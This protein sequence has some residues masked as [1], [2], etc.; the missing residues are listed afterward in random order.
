MKFK[1][2]GFF[3]IFSCGIL[4]SQNTNLLI[5][6]YQTNSKAA[7]DEFFD[8]WDKETIPIMQE[9]VEKDTSIT[10]SLY[11]L[12]Y[13]FYEC[14]N[15]DPF[16][17]YKLERYTN[18]L[19]DL[20]YFVVRDKIDYNILDLDN[21]DTTF[22]VYKEAWELAKKDTIYNFRPNFLLVNSEKVIR[23]LFLT[24]EFYGYIRDFFAT[25]EEDQELVKEDYDKKKDFLADH[26]VILGKGDTYTPTIDIYKVLSDPIIHEIDFNNTFNQARIDFSIGCTYYSAFFAKEDGKW[27]SVNCKVLST[28]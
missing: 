22:Q 15:G 1:I 4:F 14:F 20:R 2:I 18:V 8:N 11:E 17:K 5:K 24:D 13:Y 12:Y 16:A 9:E 27:G 26:I 23:P 3:V 21:I 28:C 7:L 6:A 10:S 19:Q 25:K